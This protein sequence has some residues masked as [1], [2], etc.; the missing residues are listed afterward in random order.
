MSDNENMCPICLDNIDLTINRITTE[1]GHTFHCSCLMRNVL[2]NGF[3]CPYCRITM[4]DENMIIN[5]DENLLDLT[6]EHTQQEQYIR[7]SDYIRQY[8]E[9]YNVVINTVIYIETDN[10]Q[11]ILTH[12]RHTRFRESIV[13]GQV[14]YFPVSQNLEERLIQPN[15]IW[16]LSSPLRARL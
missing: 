5:H 6:E 1:C 2:Q 8:Q 13:I 14:M 15:P 10:L 9:E 4:A 7:M 16:R 3:N 12:P 11:D